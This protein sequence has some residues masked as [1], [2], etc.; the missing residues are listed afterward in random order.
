VHPEVPFLALAGHQPMS[1][2]KKTQGGFEER[3]NHLSQVFENVKIPTRQ[4]AKQIARPAKADDIR[5]RRR[6]DRTKVCP[7]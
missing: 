5:D 3:W 1:H 7:E 6:L 2:P 4:K